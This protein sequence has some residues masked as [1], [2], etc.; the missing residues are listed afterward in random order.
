MIKYRIFL[1]AVV[2]DFGDRVIP[3]FIG[4]KEVDA[5]SD[6]TTVKDW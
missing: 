4:Y 1:V 2:E 3:Y 6:S 5:A